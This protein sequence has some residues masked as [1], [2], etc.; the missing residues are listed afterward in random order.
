[1]A[2]LDVVTANLIERALAYWFHNLGPEWIEINDDELG[3]F[4]AP[5]RN[6]LW[7]M[8]SSQCA[9]RRCRGETYAVGRP[10]RIKCE[11]VGTA[12]HTP[13]PSQT[14]A[15]LVERY[16]W[17][18]D[19]ETIPEYLCRHFGWDGHEV[20][21]VSDSRIAVRLTTDGEI[22]ASD[23]RAGFA[24]RAQ[25]HEKDCAKIA[26]EWAQILK[27]G[28]ILSCKTISRSVADGYVGAVAMASAS[29][30]PTVIH[31]QVSYAARHLLSG[32]FD[33]EV[34]RLVAQRLADLYRSQSPVPER[35]G[36]KAWRDSP[37]KPAQRL[38]GWRR[39]YW[40]NSCEHLKSRLAELTASYLTSGAYNDDDAE[41]LVDLAR[42]AGALQASGGMGCDIDTNVLEPRLWENLRSTGDFR[43]MNCWITEW[44]ETRDQ[45]DARVRL[46]KLFVE[47]ATSQLDELTDNSQSSSDIEEGIDAIKALAGEIGVEESEIDCHRAE[48][49]RDRALDEEDRESEMRQEE[50]ELRRF[51][52]AES[53]AAVDDI[54][55]SLR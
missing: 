20:R 52:E 10:E 11:I 16:P 54:L 5:L 35:L 31:N 15:K 47:F 8:V 1:M 30:G 41:D 4:D 48:E 50:W 22:A 6:A 19:Y 18:Y 38:L 37:V 24:P 40:E 39:R 36:G 13:L 32:D 27:P 2:A 45:G 43:A 34:E 7:M 26:F 42:R 55:D 29:V 44:S 3:S 12:L 53:A 25:S 21:F 14:R 9:E 49:A 17:I 33:S 23:V 51:E 28:R 46:Q